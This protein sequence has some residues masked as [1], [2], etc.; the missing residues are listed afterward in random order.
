MISVKAFRSLKF[1]D[2]SKF[3][4]NILAKRAFSW[5]R[6]FRSKSWVDFLINPEQAVSEPIMQIHNS[7]GR[8]ASSII[9]KPHRHRFSNLSL[10]ILHER[11][12]PSC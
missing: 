11:R 5:G 6:L 1:L 2:L 8:R 12:E 4:S 3:F 10:G 7:K 9:L